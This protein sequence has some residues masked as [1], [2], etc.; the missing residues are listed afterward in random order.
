MKTMWIMKA[1]VVLFCVIIAA[2]IHAQYGV[3]DK[4][5]LL[6][7]TSLYKGERFEN[8]RPKVPDSAL[9]KL[10]GATLEDIMGPLKRI[11]RK[12]VDSPGNWK[13][14]YDFQMEVG[15]EVMHPHRPL[16]GRAVTALFM[17]ARGDI[18][19]II[20]RDGKADG[21]RGSQNSWPI[22][23]LVK[24]DVLVVDMFGKVAYG[25]MVGDGLSTTIARN[26]GKDGGFIIDGGVRDADGIFEIPD[27]NTYSRG[28]HY[29]A[30]ADVMLMGVNCPVRIGE[31]VCMPGDVV[32]GTM[33][34]VVFI[35]AHIAEE[36]AD[37]VEVQTLRTIWMKQ[38]IMEG[39]YTY[40]ESHT[41]TGPIQEDFEQWLKEY[42][43]KNQ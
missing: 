35:P 41:H 9:R 34:G 11:G 31:A 5:D 25:T 30:I 13:H 38:R 40:G 29:S 22:D 8:G 2:P 12:T 16:I 33:E 37:V 6:K 42:R 10:R 3:F 32:V 43:E 1:T 14:G 4:E 23:I 28:Y 15:W 17:P 7:Y 21:R 36:V 39:K 18:N 27:Y 19:D 24:G 20:E 26:V